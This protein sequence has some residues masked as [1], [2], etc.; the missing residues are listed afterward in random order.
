MRYTVDAIVLMERTKCDV[1]RTC[2]HTSLLL[3]WQ[4][5]NVCN[6]V[7]SL[8]VVLMNQLFK[9]IFHLFIFEDALGI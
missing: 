4:S 8:S 1:Y 5:S 7:L 9:T 3:F 2:C 6:V